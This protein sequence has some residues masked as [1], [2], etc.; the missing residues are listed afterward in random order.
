MIPRVA[1]DASLGRIERFVVRRLHLDNRYPPLFVVGAPRSGTTLVYQHLVN[2]FRFA[3]LPNLSRRYPLTCVGAAAVARLLRPAAPLYTS[4]FGEMEGAGAPSDGWEVFHRWFPRYDYSVPVDTEHLHELRTIV[5]LLE[6]LYGAPFANKNNGN[7]VRIPSLS[8]VFPQA[9]FIHVTR[10]L[11]ATVDSVL[12]GRREHGIAADEW[13]AAPPPRFADRQFQGEMERVVT[14]VWG[15][16]ERIGRD[17]ADL[18]AAR[19][20]VLEYESFCD[21][22]GRLERWTRSAYADRGVVLE[23]TGAELPPSFPTRRGQRAGEAEFRQRVTEIVRELEAET[24]AG[25]YA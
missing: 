5:R 13:W 25:D 2:R 12:R 18:P 21:E 11:A 24:G 9:M 14:Q 16:R 20:L 3:F 22:P 4:R 23:E 19:W 8:A 6:G 7:S 15:L 1:V 10:D 17:L